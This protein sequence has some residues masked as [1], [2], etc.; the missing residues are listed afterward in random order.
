MAVTTAAPEMSVLFAFSCAVAPECAIL[1]L[2]AFV[3]VSTT[4]AL[5]LSTST[6]TFQIN[7]YVPAL[8][9]ANARVVLLYETSPEA[10]AAPNGIASPGLMLEVPVVRSE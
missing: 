1:P 2:V 4:S 5:P 8:L 10:A 9:S 7:R 6:S 3:S